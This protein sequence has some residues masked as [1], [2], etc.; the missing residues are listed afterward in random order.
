MALP[1]RRIF[2]LPPGLFTAREAVSWAGA[3]ERVN[4][5]VV[6]V[7]GRGRDHIDGWVKGPNVTVAAV[8]DI[9]SG[10]VERAQA[11]TAQLGGGQPRGYAD[12]RKVLEDK[13]IH[14][15]S[16]A[17]CNHWH[18]L[19]TIW[20]LRAG[21]DVYCEKPVSH[22]LREGRLMVEAARK[23]NRIVQAGM[24]SRSTPHKIEAVGLLREGV[25]GKLYMAKGLCHKRRK[26]IGR[27]PD[28]P[29][30]PGV[31]YD[32]WLGPAPMRPF[33]PNRFHYNWHWFWDTGNGDIGNQGV[34][35][36][37]ICRWGLGVSGLPKKVWSSGGKFIYD[38]DQ[39][40][41]NTQT[42]LLDYGQA[43]IEFEVRGLIANGE[44]SVE[45][46]GQ[47]TIGNIFYGSEGY[48]CLDAYGYHIY[49]GEKR[50]L[51]RQHK[52]TGKVWDTQP[53]FDNFIAAVR[54]RKQGDLNCDILEGHLSAGLCHL[55]NASYRLGRSL[56]VEPAKEN[57]GADA[58][59]NAMLT[60]KY[61][62]P[63]L[64][65]DPV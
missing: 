14:A 42:A 13:S 5:A 43:Q 39:E 15:V 52:V 56:K 55:A 18:A 8:C 23:Y 45:W 46:D 40:T 29:V 24:Q 26:S 38:D 6:G 2:L 37:D 62:A 7:R 65:P 16:I 10:N 48:L 11:F 31:D 50:E 27:S 61:R 51:V 33:N 32:M 12:M 54:S 30:P 19:G 57:F 58:E 28:G 64:I 49:K 44:G 59:A 20:A 17:T 21:K 36:L 34:H 60:R 9:D 63:Y 53:H 1:T 25:I 4:V 41:P 22:N 47:N 35:E 3:N